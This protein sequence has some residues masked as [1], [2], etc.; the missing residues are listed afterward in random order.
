M[1]K[2]LAYI[3]LLII[4][5]N[6]SWAQS[7][8]YRIIGTTNPP[9]IDGQIDNL[10]DSL[11][12]ATGFIQYEPENGKP[13]SEKTVVK[14]TYTPKA[15]Y[16]LAIN[17]DKPDKISGYLTSRDKTDQADWFAIYIDPFNNGRIA[18]CFIVTAA[19]VQIDK[20]IIG[21][22]EDYTWDAVWRS[23]VRKTSFGWIA[24][25]KI[26]FNQLRFPNKKN[27][28]WAINFL[29]NIQRKREIS[30]WNFMDVKQQSQ[31]TQMGQ[32][33][34]LHNLRQ[35][36]HLELYPY[37]SFY[38]EKWSD[39]TNA[40]TYYNGGMDLKLGFKNNLTLDMMLIPDFGEVQSDDPVLNLS[41][42]ETYYT[43]KRQFFTEGTE[44][45]KLGNIFYSRRIGGRPSKYSQVQN[46][47]L[48]NEII[49][50]NPPSTQIINAS[51][52]TGKT[53]GK[54]TFGVLNALTDNTYATV[55]DTTTQEQRKILTE[56][57][58]NYNVFALSKDLKH[59]SYLGFI[60]TNK[61]ILAQGYYSANVSA[62]E[63]NIKDN[64][65]TYRLFIRASS[66][67][68]FPDKSPNPE[69]GYAYSISL[70]KTRG[71]IKFGASRTLYSDQYYINDLGYLAQ[72][73][74]IT[75]NISL[76]YNIYKPVWIIR[77]W[78]TNISFS[79]Q[80]L[81]RNL[82]YIG[83]KI[84]ISSY[85]TLKNLASLGLRINLSP[86]KTFDYFEPRVENFVY[87]IP[88]MQNYMFW[89]STD[90]THKF[91]FDL[92]S[93]FY[94]PIENKSPQKG[95]WVLIGPRLRLGNWGLFVYH[96]KAHLDL[97][98]YGYVGTSENEDTVIFGQR[99]IRVL[100]NIINME[101]ST[102][103]RTHLSLRA[104]HYWSLVKYV[105][106]YTLSPEGQLI[107]LP[108]SYHYTEN[109]DQN[110]NTINL[111]AIFKWQFLP[112]S[113][114]SVVYRR[115]LNSSDRDI[116]PDYFANLNYIT[117]N[118]ASLN[119]FIIKLVLY[120]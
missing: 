70:N 79:H 68:I 56:P 77:N 17:Y 90:Y 3:F 97:N 117:Q 37:T 4:L 73:N 15:L 85:G 24:E 72:N 52:L 64:T 103:P 16:I 7:K 57:L 35:S 93:G 83:T 11:P 58:T 108:F 26:P 115:Q 78:K 105:N 61:T 111:E 6:N 1:N 104:R 34:G 48:P 25:I 42:Y 29:R 47:L 94:L 46:M 114:I 74:I 31:I 19:G 62:L 66:S 59:G 75:H 80:S 8:S 92:Q 106:Y 27:Q 112:G 99:N 40:G 10:W 44:I 86:D 76:S 20:K 12:A 2:L 28:T 41:P 50:N 118:F 30:S 102:S 100:E 43:E 60:N 67:V 33:V 113:E 88:P 119:T 36:L 69:V 95:G 107:L 45:F 98:N 49:I 53:K 5:G 38:V 116:I 65:E 39:R 22:S 9:K 51:K 101:V 63:L 81:Y 110:F 55:L 87:I 91:A 71:N 82:N 109:Q 96:I 32:L 13:A 21:T 54:I 89:Y 120:I 23:R 18:Y 14:L 84:Q